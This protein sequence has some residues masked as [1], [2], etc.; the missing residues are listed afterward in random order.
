METKYAFIITG[1]RYALD[2]L[3]AHAELIKKYDDKTLYNITEVTRSGDK[4]QLF[5]RIED[6]AAK[7]E[8]FKDMIHYRFPSVRV[9]MARINKTTEDNGK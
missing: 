4:S 2:I 9:M 8:R 7:A 1:D 6:D 5:V 3:Q